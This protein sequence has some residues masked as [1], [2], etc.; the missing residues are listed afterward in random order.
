[1]LSVRDTIGFGVQLS[2]EPDDVR[3]AKSFEAR[4]T[5]AMVH[6]IENAQI[7][8]HSSSLLTGV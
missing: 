6:Q 2:T 5:S 4:M 3:S 7:G 1:M 8:T